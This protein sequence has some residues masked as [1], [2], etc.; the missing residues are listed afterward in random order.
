M[1]FNNPDRPYIVV[2]DIY[3]PMECT[4]FA[5]MFLPAAMWGEK[6]GVYTCSQY[7][8]PVMIYVARVM[9]LMRIWKS[10]RWWQIKLRLWMRALPIKM[11][12]H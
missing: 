6:T 10:P 8:L 4:H 1:D 2:Q 7:N 5:D 11:V 3:E 12:T 9:A